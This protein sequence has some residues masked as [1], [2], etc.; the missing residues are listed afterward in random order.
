[1][2]GKKR[3][4]PNA[5]WGFC[6]VFEE[7]CEEFA[8]RSRFFLQKRSSLGGC[9]YV[10]LT[11]GRHSPGKPWTDDIRRD[12]YLWFS[13]KAFSWLL[14]LPLPRLCV[15]NA[16]QGGS[17]SSGNE[18]E[19]G[20]LL[21][22]RSVLKGRYSQERGVRYKEGG[23][24]KE[25]IAPP[26]GGPFR[27]E[28][29]TPGSD[30]RGPL[31]GWGAPPQEFGSLETLHS[32]RRLSDKSAEAQFF[33]C[34]HRLP[35]L[36]TT[37]GNAVNMG[38]FLRR[39]KTDPTS[40]WTVYLNAQQRQESV[41]N[42][43]ISTTNGT[44]TLA[45]PLAVVVTV[46]AFKDAYEDIQRH[47]SDKL[48]NL[49]VT[50]SLPRNAADAAEAARR[51]T[52]QKQRAADAAVRQGLRARE[53]DVYVSESEG[54]L[55]LL[56]EQRQQQRQQNAERDRLAGLGLVSRK[57]QDVR[58]GDLVVCFK[59]EAFAADVLLLGSSDPKGL[60]FIETSSLDG[61]TNLKLKQTA[62]GMAAALPS[63]LPEAVKAAK[64][65]E[66]KLVTKQ[67][68]R[69]LG[70]FEGLLHLSTKSQATPAFG[71]SRSLRPG[72]QGFQGAQSAFNKPVAVGYSQILLRGCRLR[73]T[74]WVVGLVVYT[75]KQTK[76]QM[77]SG[78]APRKLSRVERLTNRLTL[79]VWALQVFLCLLAAFLHLALVYWHSTT[80]FYKQ[81]AEKGS[82]SA[83]LFCK[84]GG[85]VEALWGFVS[86]FT[87]MVLTCNMVPISLVVQM[88]MV[89][90]LQ[91][92]FILK[93]KDMMSGEEVSAR[94]KRIYLPTEDVLTSG[95]FRGGQ[96]SLGE[97][98]A[99]GRKDTAAGRGGLEDGLGRR[100]GT[101]SLRGEDA[102]A[103]LIPYA[104]NST[105]KAEGWIVSG[106]V[107]ET[108]TS[109]AHY[110][111]YSKTRSSANS[112]R[113][114][115]PSTLAVSA[116]AKA[117]TKQGA[118]PRTSDLN[119]ELGQ[120][121]YIFSDKTGTLTRNVMEFKKCCIKGARAAAARRR[122]SC[123]A[124][125]AVAYTHTVLHFVYR[126]GGICYGT[127]MTEIRRQVLRR[128]GEPVPPEPPPL[129]GDEDTPHVRISD[130]KLRE[131]LSDPFSPCHAHAVRF[132]FHLAVNHSVICEAAE[133]GGTTYD[134]HFPQ[135]LRERGRSVF[136][137]DAG[138][139]LGGG[140]EG[141]KGQHREFC[142]KY[143]ASSPDE[144]ALVYSAH[145]FGISFLGRHSEGLSV[146]VLGRRVLVR[147]LC[148]IEFTSRRKRSSVLVHVGF[149]D[150]DTVIIP[151]LSGIGPLEE[152]MIETMEEYAKDGL[153]TLC[154]A[155]REVSP[156]EFVQWA[157]FY[158]E[159][160]NTTENRQERIEQVAEMLERNL[161][162]Q[163]ITGVEDKLQEDVG[164]T[165]EKLRQAGIKVWML[166]G[167]KVE[168]AVNIGVATSLLSETM[169]KT[170]YVWEEL[171]SKERL[172]KKLQ[173]DVRSLAAERRQEKLAALSVGTAGSKRHPSKNAEEAGGAV[174]T[175][176]AML[177][178]GDALAVLLEPDTAIQFAAVCTACKAVI[179][180]RV[181]PYQKGAVVSL[182]KE[183][184][185]EV[186]LAIGDGA[187][188]CNMIQAAD[189][190]VG[191]RG[192]E[193]MQ[194]FNTSDYGLSQFRFLQPLLLVH[195]RWNY[196]RISRLVLYMFYKNLVLVLPMFFYGA[197][198]LF[199]SQKFYFEYLYQM[200][201]VVFTAQL[202]PPEHTLTQPFPAAAGS[203]SRE[204][205]SANDAWVAAWHEGY[206]M[207]DA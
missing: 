135:R 103:S 95:A 206:I 129:P 70:V 33:F 190:G 73:N 67:P 98:A 68:N 86:F 23:E 99:S 115:D 39:H 1:M 40:D 186:T 158:E 87:W 201:N 65:F 152:S 134:L 163:G 156:E 118:W 38:N 153:R 83:T 149:P 52:R 24:G 142:D 58:V 198:S 155:Q 117:P 184:T 11:N 207:H 2:K 18:T 22:R 140:D 4:P 124:D 111:Q 132:F 128:L 44:P 53:G 109:F 113:S 47:R 112:R 9:V 107:V 34:P 25:A 92:F 61:E 56:L 116:A 170:T 176:R 137:S 169:Q 66:G 7:R 123:D 195:G 51:D 105:A 196:R 110:R 15:P 181:T 146:S 187:N 102:H 80:D 141:G 120:V 74:D 147:I 84:A 10:V 46:N 64:A 173:Q 159:A 193:G 121:G 145:H 175:E 63:S 160:E 205:L 76:I 189:V 60:A 97:A 81:F 89:K 16:L 94:R 6:V 150:E 17:K 188:D 197:F 202:H 104:K 174:Q 143:G 42:E 55:D 91:A 21:H 114:R 179:C 136:P 32:Q 19:R 79:S 194:A 82:Q 20:P 85:W 90:A 130:T 49:Q 171:G 166:T 180:S 139:P 3:L 177:V 37:L 154:I 204:H 108:G 93:D 168:T 161:E 165:I 167:D 72:R 101:K 100:A 28:C 62:K 48:E 151:L 191:L 133:D 12:F 127:G 41:T 29:E 138:S 148:C 71:S 43:V 57:W 75:G 122:L 200:Y 31:L 157:K 88:G 183:M 178:D 54:Y 126:E 182:L 78:S 192:E 77:N 96:A 27:R 36:A 185:G 14:S 50:H 172:I 5:P 131:H 203:A 30:E 69:D 26:L 106:S 35:R 45:L 162:L 164:P 125:Y 144:G 59:N 8:I 119:E 13:L 199:S